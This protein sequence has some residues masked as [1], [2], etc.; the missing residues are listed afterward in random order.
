MS[1]KDSINFVNKH[2]LELQEK[3]SGK[4]I[5]LI[6]EEIIAIGD[7]I[8]E[9]DRKAKLVA[10]NKP[11]LVEFVERGDLHAYSFEISNKKVNT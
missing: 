9:V 6:G 2:S 5:A 8:A 11:Y 1:L 7:T 10:E 4:Y 3:Y